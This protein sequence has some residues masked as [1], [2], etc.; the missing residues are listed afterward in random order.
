MKKTEVITIRTDIETKK[1]L[2]KIAA[3]KEWSIA[4]T[5]NKILEKGVAEWLNEENDA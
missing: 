5:A 2:E 4:F 3:K 1:A